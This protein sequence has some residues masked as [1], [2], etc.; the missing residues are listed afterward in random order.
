MKHFDTKLVHRPS[1]PGEPAAASS[2]PIYQSATFDLGLQSRWDYSRSGNP[3]R[4][5]L[6]Q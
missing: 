5:V 6:E 2:T 1:I 3:T 4:D